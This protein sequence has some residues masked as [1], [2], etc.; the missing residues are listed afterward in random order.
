[1]TS[2]LPDTVASV[3]PDTV[4]SLL[5]D[6]VKPATLLSRRFR[7]ETLPDLSGRV[8]VVTG[9]SAGIGFYDALALAKVGATVII[10]SANEQKGKDA[11]A[12]INK[13]LKEVTSYGSVTWHGL[14]LQNLKEVDK[15]A[16]QLAGELDR[17]DIFIANAGIGQAP[18]GLTDDGLERH[19]EV[20]NLSHYVLILRLLPLMKKT[21]QTAPPTSVRIVMQSSMMHEFAPGGVKFLSKEEI[22]DDKPDGAQLYART[23][24]GNILF[25]KE[26]AKRHLTDTEKPI[27]AISVHPGTV[28]TEVQ[29]AW[30]ETY[31]VL[32]KIL[33]QGSKLFG[34]T[35]FEGAEASLWAAASTDIFEGNWKDYQGKYFTE[36]Y[37]T[38]D[39][40]TDQAKSQELATNF[41]NLSTRLTREILGEELS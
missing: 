19:F 4:T 26:L 16:K 34:K 3:L 25:A 12:E 22:N 32:G 28:D 1:M 18:Y 17:L 9:G 31:G 30:S 35:A 15:L 6:T 20:N 7:T 40:E 14:N 10:I 27:L 21:A 2:I 11:E 29:G 36:P 39:Q 33:E 38:P 37:G 24:L 41:W 5:P 23:K 13:Q 8:V